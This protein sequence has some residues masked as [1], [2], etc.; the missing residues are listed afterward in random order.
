MLLEE[1]PVEK[2]KWRARQG[3]DACSTRYLM[4]EFHKFYGL[5]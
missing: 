1:L 4:T 2:S 5:A 3:F